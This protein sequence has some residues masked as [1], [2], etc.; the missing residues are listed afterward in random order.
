MM[1]KIKVLFIC[2]HNSARTQIAEGLMNS[3]FSEKYEAFSVATEPSEVNLYA[4]K[5][6]S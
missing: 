5:M 4:L 1:K 2:V 3:L 6:M